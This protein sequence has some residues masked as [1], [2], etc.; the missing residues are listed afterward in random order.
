[1][2]YQ[3]DTGVAVQDE[4]LVGQE[5]S[6][7]I[8]Q[9]NKLDRGRWQQIA[10]NFADHSIYQTWPY[11]ANRARGADRQL[12]RVVVRDSQGYVRLM[13]HVRI[14]RIM[15]LGLRVGYAQWGPIVRGKEGELTCTADMLRAFRD[16]YL[17]RRVDILVLTPAVW[18]DESGQRFTDML[19]SA[20][21]EQAESIRPYETSVI[22]LDSEEGVRGR[23]HKSFLRN[24]KKAQKRQI[25]VRSG[26]DESSCEMLKQLYSA[27]RKRKGFKGR[28]V[29]E[30]IEPGYFLSENERMDIKVAYFEGQPASVMLTSTLGDRVVSL[31][32][33][34]NA[35]GLSC[36][37]SYILWY[38]TAIEALNAGVKHFD[39]GGIDEKNNPTVT[40]FK[41]G[42]GGYD[43][44]H[45][46]AF[47][48]C[49]SSSVKTLARIAQRAYAWMKR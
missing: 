34:S 18:N 9:L 39:L 26:Y 5:E 32:A 17:G 21:F 10:T 23:L 25:E 24:L 2:A 15:P 14:K 44:S 20:G 13:S 38:Q 7:C 22:D 46:P 30:L 41:R 19:L 35:Y 36:G 12:S 31:H 45:I 48:A 42:M 43:M 16:A 8:V 27:S 49:S 4:Y 37:A 47:M 11:Q 28:D 40:H 33:A 6:R 1:M 3:V 29:E